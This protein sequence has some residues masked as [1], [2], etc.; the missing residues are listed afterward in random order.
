MESQPAHDNLRLPSVAMPGEQRRAE[1]TA[2]VA[3]RR[4]NPQSLERALAQEAAV[5]DAVQRDAAGQ[6]QVVAAPSR[7]SVRAMRS[8]ISSHH[9]LDRSAA[10]SI[11]RCVSLRL[12]V[13]AAARRTARRTSH[14][15][16][17]ARCR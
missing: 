1:R 5:A 14:S 10:R 17:S 11:S 7:V 6:A 3:G 16:S 2:C 9:D 12:R 13:R 4:L 15:S 8:M